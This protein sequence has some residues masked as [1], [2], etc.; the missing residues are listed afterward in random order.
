MHYLISEIPLCAKTF[1]S[2]PPEVFYGKD[3]LKIC[4]KFTGEHPHQCLISIKLES[5]FIEI[6]VRHGCSLVN[7][8]H[9]SKTPFYI[10]ISG[11]LL[12]D[13]KS[14]VHVIVWT[15]IFGPKTFCVADT[16]LT[17]NIRNTLEISWVE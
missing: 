15:D 14:R 11:G 4:R 9:I 17:R 1:E 13:M 16:G 10:N 2:S 7:L 3:I 5:N 6:T 12:L 8:L